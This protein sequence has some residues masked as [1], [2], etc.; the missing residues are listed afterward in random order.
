MEAAAEG[1][2]MEPNGICGWQTLRGETAY[3][4]GLKARAKNPPCLGYGTFTV[5]LGPLEQLRKGYS[6]RVRPI[7]YLPLY[8]KAMALAMQRNPEANAILFRK[9]FGLRIVRFEKVDVN[10]PIT[11]KVGNRSITFIG[12]IR[13]APAKSLAQIQDELAAYQ[14]CPAEASFA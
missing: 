3:L 2:L 14:R 6:R 1:Q 5:D 9:L 11:R 10:L 8:V 13:D 12:T 4:Y 7:T